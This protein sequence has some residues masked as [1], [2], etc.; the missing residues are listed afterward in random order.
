MWIDTASL[1]VRMRSLT[2]W[3]V[4]GLGLSPD[5]KTLYAVNDGG[6]I[7]EISMSSGEVVS[8]FDPAAG[9]PTAL[10]RVAS[11]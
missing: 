6:R 1:R 2:E 5:G 9:K 10:M 3:K 11:A 4:A 7:A 8:R